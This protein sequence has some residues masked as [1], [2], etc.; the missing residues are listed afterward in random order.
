MRNGLWQTVGKTYAMSYIVQYLP[1]T[2]KINGGRT[3]EFSAAYTIEYNSNV[4]SAQA[5]LIPS[6]SWLFVPAIWNA[7]DSISNAQ[8]KKKKKN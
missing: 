4:T 2:D 3:K 1:R 5:A 8:K 6:P 7:F